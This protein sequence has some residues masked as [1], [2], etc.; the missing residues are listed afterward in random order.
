VRVE[1]LVIANTRSQADA[2]FT[3]LWDQ[4]IALATSDGMASIAE[5]SLKRWFTEDFIARSP[6]KVAWVRSVI[7]AT[8]PAGFAGA[9]QAIRAINL[10]MRLGTLACPTLFIA[11]AED[12]ACPA[13]DIR[14]DHRS[15]AGSSYVELTPAAP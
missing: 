15:V 5:V 11:G 12:G 14:A 4:R 13:K 1:K 6:E 9:G 3:T 2:P 10:R 8:P 7:E